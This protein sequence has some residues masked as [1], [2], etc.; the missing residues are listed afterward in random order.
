MS[1]IKLALIV[2][3]L[4]CITAC[5]KKDDSTPSPATNAPTAAAVASH[6]VEEDRKA[7]E[8]EH[9]EHMDGGREHEHEDRQPK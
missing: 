3:A 6:G 7:R 9:D 5:D 1:S 4:L 8:H 2:G